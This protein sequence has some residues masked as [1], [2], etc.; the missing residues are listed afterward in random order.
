MAINVSH[1]IGQYLR[2]ALLPSDSL[3]EQAANVSPGG[4][5]GTTI[6]LPQGAAYVPVSSYTTWAT[7]QAT[8][9]PYNNS[10]T[11][12]WYGKIDT[13]G[14]SVLSQYVAGYGW[15]LQSEP[16]DTNVISLRFGTWWGGGGSLKQ[17]GVSNGTV[18]HIALRFR[19]SAG[20]IDIF[21]DGTA[22]A[23]DVAWTPDPGAVGGGGTFY[24]R[25]TSASCACITAQVYEGALSDSD[26]ASLAASPLQVFVSPPVTLTVS[27]AAQGNSSSGGIA[28]IGGVFYAS[29]VTQVN[30][31][32]PGQI[33]GAQSLTIASVIQS[34]IS[35]PASINPYGRLR[36]IL[37]PQPLNTWVQVNTTRYIDCLM[38][39]TDRPAAFPNDADHVKIVI[40]WSGFAFDRTYG[41]L[42]L[43][44]GGHAKYTANQRYAWNA[45]TG[46]WELM[47]LPSALDGNVSTLYVVDKKAPQSSHTYQNNV[48]LQVNQMFCSFGGAAAPS[49]GPFLED[50]SGS[51]R[52]VAPWV[53]DLSKKDPGK[54]GGSDGSGVNPARLGLNA[55]KYRRDN[56]PTGTPGTNVYPIDYMGHASQKCAATVIGGKD[57]VFFTMDTNSG[58]P[59]FYQYQFGDIRAGENDTCTYLGSAGSII[60]YEGWMVYDPSRGFCYGNAYAKNVNYTQAELIAKNVSAP[61]I[62]PNPIRLVKSADGTPFDMNPTPGLPYEC[63]YGAVYDTRNDCIWL[64]GGTSPDTG[65]VYRI[66]I[67]AYDSST[68]WAST[69]WTVD[70]ITPAGSRPNG[71]YETPILGKI[72]YVPEA[73]AFIILDKASTDGLTDPGVWMFKTTDLGPD[74]GPV[75]DLVCAPSAQDNVAAASLIVQAHILTAANATQGNLGGTGAISI[76]TGNLIGAP[77]AQINLGDTGFVC[78]IGVVPDGWLASQTVSSVLKKPGIPTGTPDWL[79]TMIEI[80][81]GR[82]CNKI[83]VPPLQNLTFSATATKAECEALYSYVNDIRASLDSLVNRLD[84]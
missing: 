60:V 36:G 28:G 23:A 4:S 50:N 70:S 27:N 43:W 76:S 56:V 61:G 63:P 53:Y 16:W 83:A 25:N 77:A 39:V 6:S 51:A 66:N 64:W 54:V 12:A 32:S 38:P 69:T 21:L 72:K 46:A 49:G 18:H 44:G 40:P 37:A 2:W 24:M 15:Y 9:D 52:R 41:R 1:P 35:A 11:I 75:N 47:C 7:P 82:R 59:Y 13:T 20:K 65:V 81:T 71:L 3:K 62:A 31:S 17:L 78:Q 22:V 68:G 67:P 5:A 74:Q 79:K 8:I 26:I 10:V 73:G 45:D 19:K 57:V 80:L 48:W 29:N 55:W 84:G 58:F 30:A 14:V 34:N 42:L 33:T